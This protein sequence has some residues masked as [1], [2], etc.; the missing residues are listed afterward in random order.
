MVYTN[1]PRCLVVYPVGLALLLS[2]SAW[3]VKSLDTLSLKPYLKGWTKS[4]FKSVPVWYDKAP[5]MV[6]N[7]HES[8]W[9]GSTQVRLNAFQFE[10]RAAMIKWQET[11]NRT[12]NVGFHAFRDNPKL[13]DGSQEWIEPG[14]IIVGNYKVRF[15]FVGHGAMERRYPGIKSFPRKSTA[16]A[17]KKI[18]AG[19]LREVRRLA[20][21][22][23]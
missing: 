6:A 20:K 2:S 19:L 13:R 17:E 11:V 10:S 12:A 3:A 14:L 16:A 1:M 18:Q 22:K 15:Y 23:K 9:Y 8:W 4:A 7:L 5:G 21:L